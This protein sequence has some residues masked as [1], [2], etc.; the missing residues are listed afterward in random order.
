MS[1]EVAAGFV[2]LRFLKISFC[3]GTPMNEPLGGGHLIGLASLGPLSL[4]TE[5]NDLGHVFEP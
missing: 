4:G 2:A 5:I 1:I 3:F